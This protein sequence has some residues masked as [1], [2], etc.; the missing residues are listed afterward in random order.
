MLELPQAVSSDDLIMTNGRD[1]ATNPCELS[2]LDSNEEIMAKSGGGQGL[3]CSISEKDEETSEYVEGS[4][5]FAIHIN[6]SN[7]NDLEISSEI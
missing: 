5:S 6:S 2:N 4:S 1:L 7:H 3:D